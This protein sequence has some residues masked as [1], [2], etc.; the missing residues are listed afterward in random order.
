ME[1]LYGANLTTSPWIKA[2]SLYH[3]FI[4]IL[5]DVYQGDADAIKAAAAETAYNISPITG[6]IPQLDLF[7]DQLGELNTTIEAMEADAT[8]AAGVTEYIFECTVEADDMPSLYQLPV[9]D[10]TFEMV[11]ARDWDI[12]D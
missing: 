10:G 11:Y 12:N 7:Y 4:D 6:N 8:A 2:S 3:Y 9:D 1:E 5:Y